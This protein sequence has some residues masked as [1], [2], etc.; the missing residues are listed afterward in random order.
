MRYCRIKTGN[1]LFY[2]EDLYHNESQYAQS[3]RLRGT[4]MKL[5]ITVVTAVLL[6]GTQLCLAD[7]GS[8]RQA[9]KLLNEMDMKVAF[10]RSID[11]MLDVQLQRNPALAPYKNVMRKFFQK[12][13]NYD[14][15]KP[16]MVKLYANA[17]TES[18]L[19]EIN[20]FYATPTGRKTIRLMPELMAK[21][22]QIGSKRVQDNI[23]ELEEMIRAESERLQKQAK[24][25][26]Q[27][28]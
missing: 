17:F 8:T 7:A 21:G 13:M 28:H 18:E 1:V 5:L 11:Q 19:K 12:Y 10:Q 4:S 27:S 14:D 6:A 26:Q 3:Q 25:A 2:R 24:S 9:E 23:Q 15:L 22:A 16:E 20:A